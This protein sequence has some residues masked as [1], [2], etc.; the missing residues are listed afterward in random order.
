M[1][2]PTGPS[3]TPRAAAALAERKQREAEALRDNL[4]R[5]K[6]Q[7]RS[8]DAEGRETVPAK[9][10]IIGGPASPY[11]RKIMAICDLKRV[12]WRCDPII[13][14]QGNDEFSRISPLRRIPVFI[15]DQVTLA[16]ST[17]IA[18]YLDERY[19]DPLLFPIGAAKRAQARWL[20]EFADT[21]MG[22]VFIWRIF[23]EAV[24]KPGVWRQPRDEA[25]IAAAL[26][27][28]LPDVMEYLE[29]VAPADGFQVR[30]TAP[31]EYAA[32][33]PPGAPAARVAATSLEFE[34]SMLAEFTGR[35]TYLT[36]P[37]AGAALSV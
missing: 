13:P 19:P 28:D 12:P 29:R 32:R 26:A 25:A 37:P 4:R 16:D 10:T 36:L 20:E 14:F 34:P 1:T 30:L 15:D 23:Y 17:A 21:R 33:R 2:A 18:E 6:Q 8:R 3:L 31:P 11:V 22:D 24:V 9:A 7:A 27:D 35:T 5:R